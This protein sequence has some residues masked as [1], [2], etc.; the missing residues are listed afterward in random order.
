M[1]S[2]KKLALLFAFGLGLC[3][4]LQIHKK[5]HL[6]EEGGEEEGNTAEVQKTDTVGG[7]GGEEFD[8]SSP[9]SEVTT[10]T[11]YAGDWI[12]GIEV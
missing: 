12:D 5:S 3:S 8:E 2:S 10:V 11:V 4:G 7:P 1:L 6:Q 9:Y